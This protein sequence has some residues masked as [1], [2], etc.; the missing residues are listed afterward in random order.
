[1]DLLNK[2]REIINEVDREMAKLFE[3][4]MRAAE[5][6]AEY[7]KINGMPI[8]DTIREEQVIQRNANMVEDETLRSYYIPF[9]QHN[10]Q[11]SRAY[12]RSILEGMRVAYSG[13][14]GAFA[15]IAAKRLFPSAAHLPFPDFAS[16]YQAVE[17]GDCEVAV[18]PIE[19]SSNGE[20]GQVSDLMF[21]G[22][23]YVNGA[24]DLAVTQ[25]LLVVPGTKMEDIKQVISHPQALGQCAEMIRQN[26]WISM[27]YPNTALAAKYVAEQ[28][29]PAIAAIE[30]GRAHV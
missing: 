29:A 5:M 10:M 26:Q 28:G 27:E 9:I 6:V 8:L 1:M 18:L 3:R 16:A 2:A 12:Q 17:D 11:I 15:H 23:L 22:S 4:R 13:T 30:I 14:E 20:V 19:N 25:D 7:K 21:S 24:F